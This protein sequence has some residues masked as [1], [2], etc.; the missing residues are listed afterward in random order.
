MSDST[1]T[2]VGDIALAFA[3]ALVAGE[4]EAA[5]GLLCDSLRMEWTPFR[6][7]ET[8]NS[9][10]EYGD[11]P[12]DEVLLISV[13]DM[14]T[15]RTRQDG[16]LGWAYVAINGDG[17]SEAVSVV[18]AGKGERPTIRDVEWGRP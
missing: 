8:L 16:D 11:G 6:L 3:R 4:F 10:V 9:M 1:E 15:W 7:E 18:V 17:Y 14:Q 5:Q 12:P 2:I 13:D